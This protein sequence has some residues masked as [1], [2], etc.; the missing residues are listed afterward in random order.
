MSS[1][2]T[3]AVQEAELPLPSTPVK[4]TVFV[5]VWEQS[6][7]VSLRDRVRLQLSLEPLSMSPVVMLADP[8][9]FN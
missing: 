1:T 7:V 5:P 8:E 9:P 4:V 3:V 2:V 6:K